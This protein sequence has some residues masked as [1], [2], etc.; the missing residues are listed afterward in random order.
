MATVTLRPAADAVIPS[1]WNSDDASANRYA[2]INNTLGSGDS[3]YVTCGNFVTAGQFTLDNVPGDLVTVT[4]V[5][6]NLRCANSLVKSGVTSFTNIQIVKSDGT[7]ALTATGST[8]VTSTPTT[9]VFTPS[10]SG[11]V[12]ASDWTNC[13]LSLLAA[14]TGS[15]APTIVDAELVVTYSTAAAANKLLATRRKAVE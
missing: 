7:T 4:A 10:L 8:N 3:S 5:T 2:R 14:R 12:S 6:L 11:P 1:G 13:R 9:Y 15:G